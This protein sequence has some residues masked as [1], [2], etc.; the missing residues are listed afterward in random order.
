MKSLVE[1]IEEQMLLEYA[2]VF[3]GADEIAEDIYQLIYNKAHEISFKLTY[4]VNKYIND[5]F[6]EINFAVHI[7]KGS[8]SDVGAKVCYQILNIIN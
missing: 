7:I 1:Y 2:G 4:N 8:F 6:K 5:K 3:N